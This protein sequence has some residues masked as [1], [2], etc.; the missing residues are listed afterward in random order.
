M[1]SPTHWIYPQS[2]SASGALF[3]SRS[4]VFFRLFSSISIT[5]A[6]LDVYRTVKQTTKGEKRQR[7]RKHGHYSKKGSFCT[8]RKV[9]ITQLWN[10]L[11]A[12]FYL[13]TWMRFIFVYRKSSPTSQSKSFGPLSRDVELWTCKFRLNQVIRCQSEKQTLEKKNDDK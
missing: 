9:A 2:R 11:G 12:A 10:L 1:I 8:I 13:P 7:K 3:F 6:M 5:T 4:P